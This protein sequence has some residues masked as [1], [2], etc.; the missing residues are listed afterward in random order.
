MKKVLFPG[1][2]GRWKRGCSLIRNHP[3]LLLPLRC[4]CFLH[5]H[6]SARTLHL[7]P[8]C[9]WSASVARLPPPRTGSRRSMMSP[10]PQ[11]HLPL[12][13]PAAHRPIFP[14]PS[15][16]SRCSVAV[17]RRSRSVSPRGEAPETCPRCPSR[18][19]SAPQGGPD[20]RRRASRP[21]R[22][23]APAPARRCGI[24]ETETPGGPSPRRGE[25]SHPVRAR[26]AP[27]EAL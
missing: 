1:G 18:A 21:R 10:H 13:P 14:R 26:P 17:C 5:H 15:R 4:C 24:S 19:F 7:P 23:L 12:P 2:G 22:R 25:Q 27:R 8:R 20:H 11:H 3:R 16:H 6:Y 9:C